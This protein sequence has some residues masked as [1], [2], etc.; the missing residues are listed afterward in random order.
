MN[1][2]ELLAGEPLTATTNESAAS[3]WRRMRE[4]G[5]DGAVVIREE[6]V[7]GVLSRHDLGGPHGGSHRRMGRTAADLMRSDFV[8]VRPETSV[9]RAVALMRG[10]GVD[11]LPVLKGPRLVGLLTVG[12]LLGL[13][14]RLS[15]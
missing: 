3:L 15:R 4:R 10:Q 1:V 11:C 9:R 13:L 14:E 6:R 2:G 8:A 5:V 7:V 12:D